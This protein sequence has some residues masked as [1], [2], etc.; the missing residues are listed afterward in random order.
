MFGNKNRSGYGIYIH[1][2]K[3]IHAAVVI[4]VLSLAVF[5]LCAVIFSVKNR[6]GIEKKELLT[7]WEGGGYREVYELSR[8][9]LQRKPMDSFLLTLCGFS[10][11]QAGIS[12]INISDTLT[13]IDECILTLRKALL[14]KNTVN[15]E[16]IYYILGKAYYYKG[17]GYADLAVKY[18]E[19]ARGKGY[20]A[21]DIPEYLGLAYAAVQDYRASV[22][23]FTLALE[24]PASSD[25]EESRDA[26][27]RSPDELL[28]SIAK[29]Y[30]ALEE[31]DSAR[32]YLVRCIET[33][34]DSGA[35][36]TARLLLGEILGGAGNDEGAE[37]QYSAV[38]EE[39]GE[40][41]EAYYRLGELYNARGDT[42]RARAEWRRALRANPAHEGVRRRL[43]ML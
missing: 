19:M 21:G 39:A 7:L 1:R 3:K 18:L 12:Q 26:G 30:M 2:K 34:R 25:G 15:T 32:A 31:P 41:A 40:N 37:A 11:Y 24:I 17:Q 20:S 29:S 9:E 38:L 14:I 36:V 27:K 35:R 43:N 42:T 33:S 16:R 28:L 22:A 4:V 5:L 13:Y 10:A 23:V 6:Q 8:A